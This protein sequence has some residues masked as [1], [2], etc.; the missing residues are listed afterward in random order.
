MLN[1]SIINFLCL[2]LYYS[3]FEC[4]CCKCNSCFRLLSYIIINESTAGADTSVEMLRVHN[5][6]LPINYHDEH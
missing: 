4:V 6:K 3:N 1:L 5:I 2:L